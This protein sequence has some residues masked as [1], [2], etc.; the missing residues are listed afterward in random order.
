MTLG[1]RGNMQVYNISV[2][3]RSEMPIWD[4][5]PPPVLDTLSHVGQGDPATVTCFSMGSHTG[6]HVD[7]PAHF[8]REGATVE[9]IPA[10]TLVGPALVVEHMGG[11]HITAADLDVMGVNGDHKR[12]LF[13]TVNQYLWEDDS[14]HRNFVAL[15]PSAAHRLIELGVSL[16]GIDYLSIEA[17][18]ASEC[19]I[20]H[21]L[22]GAGVVILEGAD[23]RKVSPGE[24]LLVCAPLKMAG[25]EGAP[26]RA[27]LIEGL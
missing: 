12:V 6:T 20:H 10:T 23:L 14:F 7:A 3:L 5:G 1:K 9:Q 26:T 15:A 19:E 4:S 24:Y 21:A 22:L 8:V 11:G 27:F 18:D 13:K 16:V 25:A 2:P 17:Y